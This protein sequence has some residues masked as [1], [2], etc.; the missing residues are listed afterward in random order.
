ML[1]PPASAGK[2]GIFEAVLSSNLS[3]PNIVHTYQ[4]AFR[5]V[6]VRW[7]RWGRWARAGAGSVSREYLPAGKPSMRALGGAVGTRRAPGGEARRA[8]RR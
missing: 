3:H 1:P 2:S 8:A 4:Y 6:T 7:A 5:P